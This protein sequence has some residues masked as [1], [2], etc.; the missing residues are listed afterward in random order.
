MP[1]FETGAMLKSMLSEMLGY[2]F[3]INRPFHGS[4][5]PALDNTKQLWVSFV[6]LSGGDSW[7]PESER[8]NCTFG[9]QLAPPVE[10]LE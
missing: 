7:N 3:A 9:F 8:R 2:L 1:R 4:A 10:R 6:V 5:M